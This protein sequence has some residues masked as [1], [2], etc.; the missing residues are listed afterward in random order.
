[1][2]QVAHPN[3]GVGGDVRHLI[4]CRDCGLFQRFHTV[5]EGDVATCARC[6]RAL[7]RSQSNSAS[8]ACTI[9]AAVLFLFAVSSPLLNLHAAGRFS[10]GTVFTGPAE[11]DRLGMSEIGDLVL[12]TLVVAP[13]L[14]LLILLT[15]FWAAK[16]PHAP[17][18]INWLFGWLERL[19]PWAMVEVFLLGMFVAYTRL[20]AI[21]EVEIG[22]ASI[23]LAGV[24]LSMV[25]ADASM[26][27]HA[28]WEGL[29]RHVFRG[30]VH[31]RA[32]GKLMGCH[33]CGLVSRAPEGS[34]CARC[35]H[36]LHRRKPHS[37]ARSSAFAIAASV[38]Y[39][40]ANALPIMIVMRLGRGGPH[41]ILGGVRELVEVHLWPLAIIVLLASV[42]VPL[43]KL[44]AITTMLVMTH[45]R[46]G[47]RVLERTKV[48]RVIAIIGRWSMIDIFAL[49][50]LVALVRMGFLATVLPEDGAIAFSAVVV[51][52][53]LSTE[54]FDPRLMWD[55]ARGHGPEALPSAIHS[56]RATT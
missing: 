12:L 35:G 44:G 29:D 46:S 48:F 10:S 36:A 30:R 51:L 32:H 55:V 52:T 14:K 6:H 43:V 20:R 47:A 4:E 49:T 33:T 25:A 50:T 54:C 38:L 27:R 8:L 56:L 11:L 41:T 53:M 28:L 34:E 39:I 45:R 13:A 22:P 18:W 2:P 26:D 3:H 7:R 15:V 23:A 40:P 31:L 21:A 5:G 24:M 19:G 9:A 17:R 16:A 1:V 37:V 42:I